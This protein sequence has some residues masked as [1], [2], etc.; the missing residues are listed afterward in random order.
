[1]KSGNDATRADLQ[2]F[3]A[4]L[5][6]SDTGVRWPDERTQL[7][8]TG[9]SGAE[10]MRRTVDFVE[11]LSRTVSNLGTAGWRGLD[12]GVGWGRIASVIG[13]FGSAQSLD[14]A[15]A[16]QKSLDLASECGLQNEM[17]LVSA[18]LRRDEVPDNTYDFIYSYSIFTHLPDTHIVNNVA[19]LVDALKPGGKLVF[20]LREPKFIEFLQRSKKFITVD[21]RMSTDGY[22]FGNGQSDD[23]GDSVVTN[24]WIT[25]N[26]GHLGNVSFRGVVSSEPFQPVIVITK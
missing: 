18:F 10:L 6:S 1:M 21:D 4:K 7:N 12:Y 23:Y 25:K 22:W 26:L 9:A 14:C 8:Y 24:E 13:F 3:G 5:L 20:T 2:S 17:K 19:I 16:W 15:D 11:L